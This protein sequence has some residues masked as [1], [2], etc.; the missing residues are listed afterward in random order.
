MEYETTAFFF[1][2]PTPQEVQVSFELDY[3]GWCKLKESDAW[4]C[5]EE[6]EAHKK[7]GE[8]M[9]AL[10]K[11]TPE[12]NLTCELMAEMERAEALLSEVRS[13]LDEIN[14]TWAEVRAKLNQPTDG[15][16]G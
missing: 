4:R 3:L 11:I 5:L 1:G 8:T 7:G 9:E 12:M 2:Q 6:R 14:V 16:D 15:T 10:P 13:T